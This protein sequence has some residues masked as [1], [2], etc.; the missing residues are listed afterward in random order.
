MRKSLC[1]AA[2]ACLVLA[3]VAAGQTVSVTLSSPQDGQTVGP[4]APVAWTIS[5]TVS[6]GD[7]FG[8]ALLATD[9]VQNAGNP[10]FADLP[11]AG[12]VPA[13]MSNFSRPAGVSNPGEGGNPTGYVGVQRGTAGAR[14]LRQIGG[15]QNTFGTATAP[16]T[17]VAENANVVSGVGQSGSIVLA[18]GTFNAPSVEGVYSIELAGV[19]ANVFDDVHSPPAYSPVQSAAVNVVDGSVTFT[20]GA[21][22]ALGDLNCDGAVDNGD[23]DAFVLALLDAG[24]YAAAFPD[25]DI[26]NAD[27][28]DDSFV[29]NADIDGFVQCLLNGGCL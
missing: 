12:G 9:L 19:I 17:G 11:P 4:G 18:S 15:G 13:A 7:N 29:D 26:N 1:A 20:V 23:I 27:I 8:L 25:C 22:F 28:N 24:A 2:C 14:N 21:A 6:A 16:G 5:F 3:S 10:A